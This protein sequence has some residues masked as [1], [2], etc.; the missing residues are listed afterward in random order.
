MFQLYGP[1]QKIFL[2]S[3]IAIILLASCTVIRNYPKNTPF[4]FENKINVKG[5]VSKD[6]KKRLQTELYNYWDDSLKVNSIQ[7]FGIRTVIKNPNEFDSA[8]INRS[9]VFMESYLRSQG[10]YNA[11]ITPVTP[12]IDTVKDQLRT[13]VQI[14]L[15]V[16]KNQ[17]ID[18]IS[19]DSIFTQ[20]LQQLAI[21]N[22]KQTLLI[23]NAP[24]T[25][26]LI[27]SELDRLVTLFR[28][29]GYYR[30]TRDNI[31]ALVD[32]TDPALLEITLDPFEQARKI[33]EANAKRRE[34]P[35]INVSIRQKAS[36]D[37][38]AF[39]KYYI[40]QIFYYPETLLSESPDS[41]MNMQFSKVT[42]QREFT[43]KQNIP[44]IKM[45]PLREHT[46]LKEG[47]IYQDQN[48]FKTI[49]SFTSMGPWSQVDTRVV[50]RQD[51]VRIL[52]IHFFLTPAKKY[53]FG[54]DVEV[55]R[56]TGNIISG[57][58]LGIAN[59]ATLRNRN[60]WKSAIQSSTNV[61][62]GI[63]LGFSDTLLQTFQ[64]SI[65]QTYSIPKFLLPW[66]P[67]HVK[68]LDD[69]RTFIDLNAA[70]TDRLNFYRL[71]SAVVSIGYEWKK[72]KHVWLYRPI[73]VELYS[74]DTLARLRTAFESN[75]FLRTAF[76]TGYVVSQ[77]ITYSVTFPSRRH[78]NLVNNLRLSAEEAGG[79]MG[80]F[81][82]LRDK[83][84]QYIK[85]E[86]EFK[87]SINWR[88][89]AFAWRFFSGVGINYSDDPKIGQSLPFF[90]QYFAGG[91]YSMRAWGVRQLGLGSSLVSDTSSTF[92]D[93]FGDVQLEADL[94]YRFPITTIG[95]V[96]INSALFTDLGN[97]WNLKYNAANPE[98]NLSLSRFWR[99][100]AIAAGTGLRLD[101]NYF[102]VRIDAAYKVKDPA[103]RSNNGWMSIKD[104][105]WRNREYTSGTLKR[106]NFSIQLGI[107]LPF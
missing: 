102:L 89:T 60:V 74:L 61:R 34:N 21:A 7:Q 88:K 62:A 53:S 2:V 17:R 65:T 91:P 39:T 5:D 103:R 9:I 99:D 69:Y 104:F 75:P 11:V 6:E 57:N 56:N 105:E 28:Q 35:T 86:G 107:G 92:R 80:R 40:G 77:N 82:G 73:N 31:Y 47:T 98:S 78:P 46:Y 24:F 8:A 48:Y 4:V 55:S 87:Q 19:Y 93:R 26:S 38:N 27:S 41:V 29:N 100:I 43:V 51:S 12:K 52:D 45:G 84:Y 3:F 64:T 13:T 76:N 71:R 106:N 66:R 83:I 54:Y 97:I 25:K 59:V 67:A 49:N 44:I 30:F 10:Y 95:G 42:A 72:N 96:K 23:K 81:T 20:E 68:R 101:F 50:E 36:A 15:D 14:D 37:S 85:L 70:Y 32:T 63:E 58:L 33:A 1:L 90:K 16:N 22:Q 94:E 18:S 79:I